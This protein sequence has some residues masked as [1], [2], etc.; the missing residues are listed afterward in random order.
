M[1][2]ARSDEAQRRLDAAREKAR[3][4]KLGKP[5]PGD[6]ADLDGA[7]VIA[8][9]DAARAEAAWD[10]LAPPAARGLLSAEEVERGP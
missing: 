2:T 8:D 1:T 3:R 9:S 5:L 4:A 10:R 6:E 7:S